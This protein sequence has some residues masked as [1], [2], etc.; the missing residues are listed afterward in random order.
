MRQVLQSAERTMTT[1][2]AALERAERTLEAAQGT[3][4]SDAPVQTDLRDTLRE[5]SRAAEAVRNLAEL[6]EREPQALLHG[7]SR[8][9]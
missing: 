4:A 1:A 3:L 2:R 6:L 5:V 9:R 8:Y 7:K